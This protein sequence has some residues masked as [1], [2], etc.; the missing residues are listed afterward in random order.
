MA[1]SQELQPVYMSLEDSTASE[2]ELD[3]WMDRGILHWKLKYSVYGA[4]PSVDLAISQAP[5][6]SNYLP[7]AMHDHLLLQMRHHY[8]H[9]VEDYYIQILPKESFTVDNKL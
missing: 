3:L 1:H 7:K 9:I 4:L 8:G 2:D 6:L 5:K